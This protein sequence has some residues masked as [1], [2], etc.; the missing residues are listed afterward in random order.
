[1][2]LRL[3][4]GVVPKSDNRSSSQDEKLRAEEKNLTAKSL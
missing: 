1:M 4:G 2:M 3:E